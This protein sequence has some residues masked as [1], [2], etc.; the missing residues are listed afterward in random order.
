VLYYALVF[1][2]IAIDDTLMGFGGIAD[3]CH[4]GKG[5]HSNTGM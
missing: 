2:I 1:L 5:D 4:G 3:I